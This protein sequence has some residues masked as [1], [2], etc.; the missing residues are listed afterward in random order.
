MVQVMHP[1]VTQVPVPASRWCCAQ[2]PSSNDERQA[3]GTTGPLHPDACRD[4]YMGVAI[5]S[6]SGLLPLLSHLPDALAPVLPYLELVEVASHGGLGKPLQAPGF[7][8]ASSTRMTVVLDLDETLVHCRLEHFPPTRSSFSV[9]FEDTDVIGQVYV[10]PFARLF[11]EVATRLFNVYVFTASS[12]GYAD[13]VLDQL[14][15]FKRLSGRLYRQHC[16]ER[17][18]GFLKDLRSLGCPMDRS[19]L[20]DNSPVSLVLCPDNG[21]LVSSWLGEEDRGEDRELMHLLLLLQ[22]CAQ[23]DSVPKFLKDRFCFREFLEGLVRRADLHS[24]DE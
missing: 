3:V 14:D 9:T 18:G 6:F 7:S 1:A 10:R 23:H 21:V 19:V 2:V 11:L 22:E 4:L 20:V 5:S 24:T 12:Q 8:F 15:P 17:G 13:Q 16:T